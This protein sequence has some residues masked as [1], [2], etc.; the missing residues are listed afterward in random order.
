MRHVLHS[1]FPGFISSVKNLPRQ[2]SVNFSHSDSKSRPAP[3]RLPTEYPSLLP[4]ILSSSNLH[5]SHGPWHTPGVQHHV[6]TRTKENSLVNKE[7]V[8]PFFISSPSTPRCRPIGFL[9]SEVMK[10]LITDHQSLIEKKSP[11]EITYSKHSDFPWSVSFAPWV[12]EGGSDARTAHIERLVQEWRQ[13]NSFHDMLRGALWYTYKNQN[14]LVQRMERW[15]IPS[16]LPCPQWPRFF[17]KSSGILY[18]TCCSPFVWISQLRQSF[19]RFSVLHNFFFFL[20]D[21]VVNF[22]VLPM[23]RFR[24][25]DAVDP[26]TL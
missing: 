18:W 2:I 17:P 20:S 15:S 4:L 21:S 12:N 22:S 5:I 19:D 13:T 10:A 26:S 24:K 7:L 16:P 1:L 6:A 9:G 23:Q 14:L 3:L 8:V 25:D 11:W